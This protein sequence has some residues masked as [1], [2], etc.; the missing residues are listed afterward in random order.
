M[1]DKLVILS[2]RIA[3]RL[4]IDP[5][6]IK[7]EEL[8]EDDSRL[9]VDGNP[10]I[11]IN[12][13]YKNDYEESAKCVAHEMRHIFQIFYAQL[14]NDE[15]AKRWMK[16]LSHTINS[17]NLAEGDYASQ[18]LE[19]DAFAFTKFY[20]EAFEGIKVIN[21]IPGYEEIIV[22]YIKKNMGFM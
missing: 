5:I 3:D 6:T 7:Y 12:N 9:Y 13:K 1:T 22:K 21:K 16:E 17:S 19:L 4:G 15:R 11:G 8:D 2:E 14:F 20:L 10:Y 18:E